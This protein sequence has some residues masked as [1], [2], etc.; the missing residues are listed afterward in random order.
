MCWPHALLT[1]LML[2]LIIGLSVTGHTEQ[3][4]RIVSLAPN[5]TEM[6]HVLGAQ[7]M[8]VGRTDACDHPAS[9]NSVPSVG[10]FGEPS[11][12][13]IAQLE[14]DL[15]LYTD[16]K[17]VSFR[18]KMAALHIPSIPMQFDHMADL[19]YQMLKLGD[20]LGRPAQARSI[21]KQWEERLRA[22]TR[23]AQGQRPIRVYF[24][25]WRR[26]AITV[27]KGS[28]IDEL[29]RLAGGSNIAHE[30]PSA[31]PK[32]GDEFVAMA[33]PEIIVLGYAG[34]KDLSFPKSWHATTAVSNNIII[35]DLNMDLLLR[36]GPRVFD[37]LE[38]LQQ[39]FD[40]ARKALYE[41][42]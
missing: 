37:G 26:P 15:V 39:R 2:S 12:E 3:M 23:H 11:I 6:I 7:D 33:D 40:Q 31:Y 9:V 17:D 35:D 34:T 27:G 41:K 30:L 38:Q 36:P 21:V 28:F 42:K 18:E 29:I 25:V 10:P 22:V 4:H 24:E 19:Q 1:G 20:L 14:P 32:P 8:L 13:K 16:I 5:I